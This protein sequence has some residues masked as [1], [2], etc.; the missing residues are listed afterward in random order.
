MPSILE[1]QV[2][3]HVG[4][5]P[6]WSHFLHILKCYGS[7]ASIVLSATNKLSSKQ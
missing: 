3:I 5:L 7:L 4:K 1:P 6:W 2:S